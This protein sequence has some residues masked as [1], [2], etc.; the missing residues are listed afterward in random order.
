MKIRITN[1]LNKKLIIVFSTVFCCFAA[2]CNAVDWNSGSLKQIPETEFLGLFDVFAIQT[3]ANYEKIRTWQGK[4]VI[5]EYNYLY[6]DFVKMLN[7]AKDDP[8]INSSCIRRRVTYTA[9]FT[10]DVVKNKLYV[11]SPKPNVVFRALDIDKEVTV[12]GIYSPAKVIV[13]PEK[14]MHYEPGFTYGT[15]QTS[16]SYGISGKAAFLDP[17]E[18]AKVDEG[19]QV[20]D[21]RRYFRQAPRMKTWDTLKRIR[22]FISE[23][24][25]P[26]VAGHPHYKIE[27]KDID[28]RSLYK[29]TGRF[30]ISPND[31]SKVMQSIMVLDGAVGYNLTHSELIDTNGKTSGTL[32]LTY[33]KIDDVFIP[34]TAHRK[35]FNSKQQPLFDS[36]ITITNSVLNKLIP[37]ETFTIENLGLENGVRFIDNIKSIEYIYQ[38]GKLIRPSQSK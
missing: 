23:H 38:N 7:I 29:L 28:G 18:K 14:Y 17:P 13:T 26:L 5:E 34:K 16:I 19:A 31:K 37:P 21:P 36:R 11:E 4:L 22:D 3:K 9:S 33:E 32:D 20:R 24:G 35:G 30:F 15:L 1:V 8:A 6:G 12:D 27:K 10:I 25:N 2:P